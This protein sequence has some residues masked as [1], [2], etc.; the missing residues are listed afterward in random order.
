MHLCLVSLVIADTHSV[1]AGLTRN[2]LLNTTITDGL[3][4]LKK[5]PRM[6]DVSK[7]Y[8]PLTRNQKQI[9]LT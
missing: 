6:S 5:L 3:V 1:I 4:R 8:L 2:P 9:L 7:K